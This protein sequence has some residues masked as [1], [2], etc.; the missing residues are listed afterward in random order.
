MKKSTIVTDIVKRTVCT[1]TFKI[2]RNTILLLLLNVFQMFGNNGYSQNT[3]LTLN[4]KDVTIREALSDIE[5]KS[6][7][8]FLYNSKLVDDNKKISVNVKNMKIDK[9]LEQ[10]F[11]NS[12]V[13]YVVV[14]KQII[15]TTNERLTTIK[16]E[17]QQKIV[18]G[19]VEDENGEALP[20][21]T[22]LEKGTGN[23]SITDAEGKYSLTV[24][25]ADAVLV[26]SFV[27]MKT[28]EV[29]IGS[30]TTIDITLASEAIGLNEVVAVGYGTMKKVNLTGALDVVSGSELENRPASNVSLLLQGI[31][32]NVAITLNNHGGEP[33]AGQNWQIRGVGS[34]SGND[35]PLIL[36]DG[37]EMDINLLDPESIESIS[38][39]KDASASAIYGS[40]AAFGVVLVTTKKGRLNKPI[41]IQYSNNL[42][43]AKPIYVP[44]MEDAYTYAI[45]F[46]QAR[47]N[48]GLTPTFP[49]EQVQRIQEYMAGTYTDEYDVNNPPNSLW[50]G[51]WMGNANYN[52]T[53]EYYKPSSFY[54]KHNV[55]LNGGDNKTQ[56]YFNAGLYDQPGLYSWGDDSYKRYNILANITS[57]VNNW[58]KFNFNSKYAR[59]ESDN[60]IGMVGLPRTYTWSQ[61]IDFWPTMPWHN[62]DGTVS[63]PLIL[64][65]EQG[66]RILSQ[67]QDLRMNFGIELE[68]VK[69]WKT[70]V[71]YDYSYNWGSQTQNPR[72]V[73]VPVPNGTVGNIGD[74]KAGYRSTL[75]QGQ[76]TLFNAYTSYEKTLG[77]HFIKAMVGYE[78]DANSN[79]GLF[80]EKMDLITQ[81]VPSISTALG[82]YNVD[83]WMSHWA[84]E[85]VFGRLNYNY[86][87]KYLV[88]FSARYDG[89]SS[90]ASGDRW[91]F[92]PSVS[93]GYNLAKENY[94]SSIKSYVNN[95]KIRASYGSL[96]NQKVNNPYLYLPTIPID[97]NRY[98]DVYSNPGYIIDNEV[99]LYALSPKIVSADLTWETITTFDAGL[100]AGF[101]NNRLNL[102][103]DWY[104]RVTSNMIGPALTL[105]SLLGTTP[106]SSNNAELSTKGLEIA[107]GWRDVLSPQFSYY[108]RLNVGHFETTILKYRN[109]NGFIDTWYEGK[110]Y[111]EI[112]GY[113]TA[114]I[115]QSDADADLYA[116]PVIPVRHLGTRRH[117]L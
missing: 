8:F 56:Y 45:A 63:N 103:F 94:W 99:P 29:I 96:G 50:R 57:N 74:S 27:G 47:A 107:I 75:S 38:I 109:E 78:Q 60:P 24:S 100:D 113:T 87:E 40:K 84:T 73:P 54:Q 7:F 88:E 26:F 62:V 115:L 48:A 12:D 16:K 61:F 66:G 3:I 98:I 101:M 108:A 85:G 21:V 90:F 112:W 102:V 68:P 95:F 20:G 13:R 64:A 69:G 67:N 2:M 28:Q 10:I 46:N 116:R 35:N 31:S 55:S 111:G 105:P 104:N 30:R 43:I 23:G 9:I 77:G 110:K 22:V 79:R 37:V 11:N 91:G 59:T 53:K 70:N 92:F 52:W 58:L 71:N 18:S 93:A 65:L 80:G 6:E 49:D 51:R 82:D 117:H 5:Q 17:I 86:Q 83:D 76:Y 1:K 15:L 72:P 34:I 106:P 33:G 19:I 32:P 81:D 44:D 4:L 14:D 42:S 36:V 97:Y 25:G 39:L 89:S 41:Q 114:G